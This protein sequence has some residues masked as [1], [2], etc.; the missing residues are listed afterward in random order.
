MKQLF[1]DF[2]LEEEGVTA[3]EYA[4]LASAAAGAVTG[5]ASGFYTDLGTFFDGI[6]LSGDSSGSGSGGSQLP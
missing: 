4:L 6:T 3:V 2:F 5:I 1:V